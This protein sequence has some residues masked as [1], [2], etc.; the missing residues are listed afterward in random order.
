MKYFFLI[1]LIFLLGS[2]NKRDE[3]VNFE[4]NQKQNDSNETK[5][6]VQLKSI[7]ENK[8]KIQLNNDVLFTQ[9]KN[10]QNKVNTEEISYVTVS[11]ARVFVFENLAKDIYKIPEL[12]NNYSTTE[13]KKSGNMEPT[14]ILPDDETTLIEVVD[15][16]FEIH[17]WEKD[18][19]IQIR[20]II[21]KS[22]TQISPLREYIG[23][24][25]ENVINDFGEPVG[26][27][28]AY[29]GDYGTLYY[30]IG[31]GSGRDFGECEVFFHHKKY[32]IDEISYG[33]R[34]L[35]IIRV[36]LKI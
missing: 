13:S 31:D 4:I 29:N 16:D 6:I 15:E 11:G 32:I 18:N 17:Y 14:G 24:S 26:Q 21:I 1:V 22:N 28:G 10:I 12:Y 7:D 8:T 23:L 36:G 30:G 20:R 19:V 25:A 9:F 3:K 33:F 2:C 35:I 27:D 34:K 5:D